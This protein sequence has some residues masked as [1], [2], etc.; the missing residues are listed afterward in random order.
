MVSFLLSFYRPV[1]M[2]VYAVTGTANNYFG[3]AKNPANERTS[4]V[5]APHTFSRVKRARPQ[6]LAAAGFDQRIRLC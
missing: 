3:F 5:H 2:P 1:A 4:I 6:T